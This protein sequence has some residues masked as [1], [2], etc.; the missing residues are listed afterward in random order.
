[1]QR[2][3]TK[4]T[5]VMA[6]VLLLLGGCGDPGDDSGENINNNQNETRCGNGVREGSEACDDGDDNSDTLPDACRTSCVLPGCGD[7][8]TDDGEEC[9]DGR[10]NSNEMPDA[11]RENC[12]KPYCGDG[13]VDKRYGEKCDDGNSDPNDGCHNCQY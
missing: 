1:M 4:T 13:I 6:A 7:G 10:E 12:K 11:C 5:M 2:N 8:V 9:D 3:L